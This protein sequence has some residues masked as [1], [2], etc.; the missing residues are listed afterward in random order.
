MKN[1]KRTAK[2]VSGFIT[3]AAAVFAAWFGLPSIFGMLLFYVLS[4]SVVYIGMKLVGVCENIVNEQIR[5][6]EKISWIAATLPCLL[7][8]LAGA[9][10]SLGS[11]EWQVSFRY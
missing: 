8:A 10:V 3:G 5:R 2:I 7:I 1:G 4:A 9:R 11:Q 6:G